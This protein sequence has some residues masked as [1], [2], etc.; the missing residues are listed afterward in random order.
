M[1]RQDR[2]RVQ[3]VPELV[4][5]SGSMLLHFYSDVAYNMTGFNVTFSVNSC[6]S[7][8]NDLTCSGHGSCDSESGECVCD[9]DFK[10]VACAV[11]TCP[12]QCAAEDGTPRGTCDYDEKKCECFSGFIGIDSRL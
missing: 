8:R 6:P 10:G 5:T 2:Y 9:K 11:P 4:G 1:V 3:K 7:E 12:K